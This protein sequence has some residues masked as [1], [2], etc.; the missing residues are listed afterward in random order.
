MTALQQYESTKIMDPLS[1][2][3]LTILF[4]TEY[5]FMDPSMAKLRTQLSKS[6]EEELRTL[7]RA[8]ISEIDNYNSGFG[9]GS[10]RGRSRS[11][12]I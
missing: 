7:F 11:Y 4:P 8:K 12:G 1:G 6:E 2:A 3:F 5:R 10:T 9:G